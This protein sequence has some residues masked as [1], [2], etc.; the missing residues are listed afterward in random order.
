MCELFKIFQ[1]KMQFKGV[2]NLKAM[3]ALWIDFYIRVFYTIYLLYIT[4]RFISIIQIKSCGEIWK[5]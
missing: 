5:Y 1:N 2:L 3:D 4:K